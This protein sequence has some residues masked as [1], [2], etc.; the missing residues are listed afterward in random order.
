M[1]TEQ[2]VRD[3]LRSVEDDEPSAQVWSQ[4][5]Q[6][7]GQLRRR[8]STKALALT[9]AAIMLI[10]ASTWVAIDATSSSQEADIQASTTGHSYRLP[11]NGWKPGTGSMLSRGGGEFHAVLTPT[12]AC[13]WLGSGPTTWPAGYRVR[14]NPTVLINPSGRV[15]AREGDLLEVGGG[16]VDMATST[17]CVTAGERPFVIQSEVRRMR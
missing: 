10:A 2:R 11:S 4:I 15:I 17:R 5:L 13:A 3:A 9:A 14:F 1:S 7:G 16:Y 8:R 12:G 6:R